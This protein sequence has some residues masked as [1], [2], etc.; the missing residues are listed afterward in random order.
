MIQIRPY[1]RERPSVMS[2]N[3]RKASYH[4]LFRPR[5]YLVY[6]GCGSLY[7][8]SRC[9]IDSTCHSSS[10]FDEVSRPGSHQNSSTDNHVVLR[11][12]HSY[13]NNTHLLVWWGLRCAY[14]R[15]QLI[16]EEVG[17]SYNTNAAALG[18]AAQP[19]ARWAARRHERSTQA[20]SRAPAKRLELPQPAA[21]PAA[22]VRFRRCSLHSRTRRSAL[23]RLRTCANSFASAPRG[24]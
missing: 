6:V 12:R 23:D 15:L 1:V 5:I 21:T 11:T 14:G 7:R 18:P 9:S 8:H 13:T 20:T 2:M 22:R 24:A 4:L 17:I 3:W 16:Q 10:H 19:P